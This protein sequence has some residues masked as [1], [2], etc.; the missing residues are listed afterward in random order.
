MFLNHCFPAS[1]SLYVLSGQDMRLVRFLLELFPVPLATGCCRDQGLLSQKPVVV[2][3]LKNALY[4]HQP[5][6]MGHLAVTSIQAINL[7]IPW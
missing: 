4:F 1:F 2:Q 7:D 6:V 5:A 3:F